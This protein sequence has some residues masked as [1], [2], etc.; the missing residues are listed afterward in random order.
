MKKKLVIACDFPNKHETEKFLNLFENKKL[1]L[2]IGME[3]FCG[4]GFDFINKLKERGHKVFLDLKLCDIPNTVS[5]VVNN[6]LNLEIDVLT[7]HAFGGI[8]MMS[9]AK[10]A[11]GKILLLAVTVLTSISEETFREEIF[12]YEKFFSREQKL[13]NKNI[14]KNA[15]FNYAK[16]SKKAG[17]DGVV[18]SSFEIAEIKEKIGSDFLTATPGIRYH[19]ENGD[20]Q[21][22]TATPQEAAALGGDYIIVGRPITLAENPVKEYEKIIK[23]LNSV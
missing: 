4:T 17:I 5:R 6:L 19:K 13:Q 11:A 12:P 2:K 20:D 22:R 14:L 16:N 10:E 3:L 15:V 23:I 8:K 7:I 21:S 18:C 9:A 1:F